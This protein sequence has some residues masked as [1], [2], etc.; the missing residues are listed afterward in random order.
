MFKINLIAKIMIILAIICASGLYAGNSIFS[1]AGMPYQY[2]GNDVYSQGLGDASI[3]DGLRLVH[4]YSNPALVNT[5]NTV[6][7]YTALKSG[8]VRYNTEN[9]GHFTDEALDFPFFSIVAPYRKHRFAFQFNSSQS[10]NVQNRLITGYSEASTTGDSTAYYEEN[11]IDSYIYKLDLYYGYRFSQGWSIGFGPNI[12]IGHREQ[13]YIQDNGFDSTGQANARYKSRYTFTNVGLTAGFLKQSATWSIG[14]R[15][16]MGR[17]FDTESEYFTIHSTE[18]LEDDTY[19][20]PHR[21]GL[22]FAKKWLGK[23]KFV[24]DVNY[25]IWDDFMGTDYH[26][27]WKVG[28]GFGYEPKVRKNGFWKYVPLRVG[29]SYRELPFDYNNEKIYEQAASFGF[30]LPLHSKIDKID[31]AVE[32][33]IRG[34]ESIHGIE[35]RSLMLN[36]GFSGFDIFKK[37]YRRTEPREIPI[38]EDI[39]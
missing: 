14:A 27:A 24:S 6:N 36:I 7:F 8:Y 19:K 35:D 1:V 33:L 20:L 39:N 9:E 37:V 23:F 10:G 17:D 4:G 34:D 11:L 15:Y 5:A 30:S 25:E 26:N 31:I 21:F 16:E 12:Y 18:E 22:G 38:K 28:L 3:G 32:Y 13:E 29:V 2:L